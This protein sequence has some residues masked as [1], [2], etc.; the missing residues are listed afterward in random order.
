[1]SDC[2]WMA[3]LCVCALPAQ[4]VD[5][6]PELTG[7]ETRNSVSLVLLP[8]PSSPVTQLEPGTSLMIITPV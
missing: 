6:D 2:D 3:A 1:M 7:T 8:D 4:C 5:G